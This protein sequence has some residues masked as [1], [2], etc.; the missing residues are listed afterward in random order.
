[1]IVFSKY[2]VIC[3]QILNS[4][5]MLRTILFHSISDNLILHYSSWWRRWRWQGRG[6]SNWIFRG[7]DTNTARAIYLREDPANFSSG[8]QGRVRDSF[9]HHH[10][11]ALSYCVETYLLKRLEYAIPHNLVCDR[12]ANGNTVLRIFSALQKFFHWPHRS[13]I[14]L[15]SLLTK[16]TDIGPKK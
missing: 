5:A 13:A 1:M 12:V 6:L 14:L 2:K 11:S 3:R 8:F 16:V 9:T 4:F 10:S 15:F 7:G